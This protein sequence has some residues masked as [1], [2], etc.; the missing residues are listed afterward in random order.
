MTTI[1]LIW[2]L[3]HVKDFILMFLIVE[4]SFRKKNFSQNESVYHDTIFFSFS[5]MC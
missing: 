4:V 3:K 2:C 5:W 1:M